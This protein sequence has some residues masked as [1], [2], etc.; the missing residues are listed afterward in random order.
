MKLSRCRKVAY[1][2]RNAIPYY[3]NE[4]M[5]TRTRVWCNHLKLA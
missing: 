2:N 3:A 5:T 1:I 4:L